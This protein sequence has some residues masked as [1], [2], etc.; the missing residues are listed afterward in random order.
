MSALMET[1]LTSMKAA[2]PTA[3]KPVQGI[4]MLQSLIELMLH[5]CQCAQTHEM[6]ASKD[7]NMLFCTA[8][9]DLYAFFTKEA[10][11]KTFFLFP[12]EVEEVPD[13][14]NCTDGNQHEML[15]FTHAL[16]K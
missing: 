13:F 7:M 6:P 3:P 2:F 1:S 14:N 11:P 9:P 15:K 4:L 16:A 8:P 10:Y 5:T 12:K